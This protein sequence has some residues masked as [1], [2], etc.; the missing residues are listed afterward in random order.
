MRAH[1]FPYPASRAPLD[2]SAATGSLVTRDVDTII[3]A[4]RISIELIESRAQIPLT[5]AAWNALVARNETNSIFQTYE[6]F[7]A[8]WQTFGAA[9]RL[10]FLLLRDNDQVIGFA[11][12]MLRRRLFVGARLEFVG[13]GNADYQDVVVL[14]DY[15]AAAM[16]AICDFL[17]A[18]ATRWRSAWLCN[19]PSQSST[20]IHLRRIAAA[21]EL[22]LVDEAVLRCPSLQLQSEQHE[23]ER[24]LKKYSMKRPLNWFAARGEVQF[25]HLS[26]PAEIQ[27]QL[28]VFFD[29]HARRYHAAGRA[30][31]FES[32]NQRAFYVA[33]AAALHSAGWLLFSVVEF[34][35]QP[36]AFHF[37]FDYFGSITWYK[38][39]FEVRYAEHS[40]GLL[41]T[42]KLIEDGMARSRREV[43]FTIGDEPFKDRFANMSR[44]NETLRMYHSLP[45]AWRARAWRWIRRGMGRAR[46]GVLGLRT[47]AMANA[48]R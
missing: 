23:A 48:A 18:H 17:H 40:P 13:T 5:A 24:L 9:H 19:I 45:N 33:L 36:I 10:F 34:N 1:A 39:S 37:G 8:W 4:G 7:D 29:Q 12:L 16:V 41:L 35:G 47:M 6:W 43:D 26:S 44:F 28:P 38:P 14:P 42:R 46:R 31:L 3:S 32:A 15:K 30:S 20:L 11:P 22:Y 21:R 2:T 25:R 27:N